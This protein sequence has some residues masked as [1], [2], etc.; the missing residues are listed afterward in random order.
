MSIP[1]EYKDLVNRLILATRE[2]RVTWQEPFDNRGVFEAKMKA[3]SMRMRTCVT[4]LDDAAI[5]FA[6]I[7]H[8]GKELHAFNVGETDKDF[9]IMSALY[10]GAVFKARGVDKMLKG[11]SDELG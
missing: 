10:D 3:G 8:F 9:K 4:D 5:E 6:V 11:L 2:G 7:D 1:D